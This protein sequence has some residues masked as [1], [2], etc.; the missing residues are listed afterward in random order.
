MLLASDRSTVCTGACAE[1]LWPKAILRLARDS[2]IVLRF[3]VSHKGPLP[4]G[5]GRYEVCGGSAR[6]G[7][8]NPCGTE[9]SP[10]PAS[11]PRR[12]SRTPET[13]DHSAR[14]E[15]S[16]PGAPLRAQGRHQKSHE[17]R[18]P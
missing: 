1:R 6:T 12:I 18:L 16:R 14:H 3:A 11:S 17:K 5:D 7:R 9:N 4:P 10:P 2:E 15:R 8:A 13:E